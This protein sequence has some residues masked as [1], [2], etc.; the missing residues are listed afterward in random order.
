MREGPS[1]MTG[2]FALARHSFAAVRP[3]LPGQPAPP[4]W[5]CV[6]R[7]PTPRFPPPPSAMKHALALSSLGAAITLTTLA[8]PPARSEEIASVNTNFRI[9]GS[10]RVVVEAY[11]DPLVEV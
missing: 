8:A 5:Y 9:T 11:D 4:L 7:F 6:P 1:V 3:P 10:D 2:L